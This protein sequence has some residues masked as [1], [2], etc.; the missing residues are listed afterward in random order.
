[1]AAFT[2]AK[3]RQSEGVHPALPQPQW[4]YMLDW[5]YDFIHGACWGQVWQTDAPGRCTSGAG[6]AVMCLFDLGG[7]LWI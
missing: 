6:L 1:M 5:K 3:R 2:T 4:L 7:F